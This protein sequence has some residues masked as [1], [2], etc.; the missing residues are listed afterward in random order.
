MSPCQCDCETLITLN[1]LI[2]PVLGTCGPMHRS[3][4]FLSFAPVTYQ[5]RLFEPAAFARCALSTL[6]LL[7]SLLRRFKPSSKFS[8]YRVNG[9]SSST[10]F[11]ILASIF[12]KSD[13]E[14]GFSS[15]MS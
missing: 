14:I 9:R 12:S 6:Y 8:S 2:F 10:I 3:S 13:D 1:A 11:F 4:Q 7:P 15:A 5:L